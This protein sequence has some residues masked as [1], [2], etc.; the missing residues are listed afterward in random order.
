[1]RNPIGT[2]QQIAIEIKSLG[3]NQ[4]PNF[5]VDDRIKG[6]QDDKKKI[7]VKKLTELEEDE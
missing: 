3:R 1:M 5:M 2:R 7:A 6:E 4:D